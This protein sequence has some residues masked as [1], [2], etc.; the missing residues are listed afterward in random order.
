MDT[1]GRDLATV[2]DPGLRFAPLSKQAMESC[3]LGHLGFQLD[4]L[5]HTT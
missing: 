2:R 3:P 1:E 5:T 4:Q